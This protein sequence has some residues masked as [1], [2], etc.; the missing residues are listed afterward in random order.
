E[1][2]GTRS[3][4]LPDLKPQSPVRPLVPGQPSSG[5]FAATLPDN[6]PLTQPY[7]LREDGAAGIS[8]VSDP[9]LI[10]RPES[11]PAAPIEYTF[12]IN[13]Q[14]LT[15]ADEPVQ[16]IAGASEAQAR[17]PMAVIPPVVLAL[18][19]EVFIVAPGATKQV[20]VEISAARG[21]QAGSLQLEAPAGWK[22]APSA[23]P[24]HLNAVGD[25][26][27][28]TFS[29]TSP[30]TASSGWLKASAN[31]GGH[32]YSNQRYEVR[33]AHIPVQLL[34]PPA[35]ARVASFELATKGLNIG[36]LPGAGD[37]VAECLTQMG[38]LVRPLTGADL[39]PEKLKGLDVVVIGVRAFNERDDLKTALPALF[40]WVEQGGTVIA[41]YNRPNGL[42]ATELGPY[43]LSIEGPAPKLRVTDEKAPVSFISPDQRVLNAPNK[44]GAGDFD[45]WVQ[46]R[47]AYFPSSWDEAH[48][49]TVLSMS[50]PGEAPLTSSILIAKHGQGYYIYTGVAF[51]RQ[52]PAGVPGAYRLFANLVSLGK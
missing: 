38:Y 43:K 50:D 15:I 49:E 4:A 2:I 46:E 42:Q 33:Y 10:G 27:S 11:P 37:Y 1:M 25:K 20:T 48:Y 16:L 28:V 13:G 9:S 52:L 24:F 14:Q 32:Q 45:G 19:S 36:Y 29:I 31:V 34:Q 40:A 21:N 7:W 51:F 35:R 12:A 30:A 39:T 3:P 6:T 5:E 17:K 23:Q 8:R 41:Q 18:N 26:A 22:I 47:G 44:I